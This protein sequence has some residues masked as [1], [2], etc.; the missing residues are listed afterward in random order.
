[1]IIEVRSHYVCGRPKASDFLKSSCATLL[2]NKHLGP[3][4]IRKTSTIYETCEK[5]ITLFDL[6][7]FLFR[8]R[9][10]VFVLKA[11]SSE[12]VEGKTVMIKGSIS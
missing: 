5:I 11:G 12:V 10:R 4:L 3:T 7:S 8:K 6:M 1:M 9:G 2:Q